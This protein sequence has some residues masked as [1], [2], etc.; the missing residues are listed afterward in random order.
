MGKVSF[1]FAVSP[2]YLL[3][4]Q[5]MF[6]ITASTGKLTLRNHLLVIYER[7]LAVSELILFSDTNTKA[8]D[9]ACVAQALLALLTLA[10]LENSRS[11]RRHH[12][13]LLLSFPFVLPEHGQGGCSF[14]S[15]CSVRPHLEV[16]GS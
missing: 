2:R 12:D 11:Y 9:V 1:L 4:F 7:S 13:I 16:G 5:S 14:Q 6:S 15:P 10:L 8:A 3:A